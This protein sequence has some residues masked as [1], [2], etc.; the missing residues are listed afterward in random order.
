MINDNE[1]GIRVLKQREGVTGKAVINWDFNHMNFSSIYSE[2]TA[3][4][5]FNGDE[6]TPEDNDKI[7]SV[8]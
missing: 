4:D 5:D 1:M 3:N 8:D 2:S 6:A 7:M